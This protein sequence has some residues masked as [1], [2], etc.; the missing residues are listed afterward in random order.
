MIRKAKASDLDGIFSVLQSVGTEKKE[1]LQGFLMNDYLKNEEKFRAKYS[2]DLQKLSYKYVYL[3]DNQIK[4]FLLAYRKEE[5][6]QEVP[7][8]LENIY[9]HPQFAKY[10]LENFVLIN[11]TALLPG[12]TGQGIGSLLYE[13][14]LADL[15]QAGIADIFAETII[16]PMP[17][18]AS[19]HFRMKQNYMLAGIRYERQDNSVYTTLV[20]HKKVK[21]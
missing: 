5:W 19:L 11:Q 17:N 14:L 20:Y 1:A 18:I 9:W 8:W 3:E 10:C 13:A 12:S 4:G 21:L 7:N 16:A 15:R 6:L 2:A